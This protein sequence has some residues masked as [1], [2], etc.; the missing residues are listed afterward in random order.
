MCSPFVFLEW[1]REACG[2]QGARA[3]RGTRIRPWKRR[4]NW[5]SGRALGASA[6]HAQSL[7]SSCAHAGAETHATGRSRG[8][9]GGGGGAWRRPMTAPPS[10]STTVRPQMTSNRCDLKNSFEGPAHKGRGGNQGVRLARDDTQTRGAAPLVDGHRL[11]RMGAP[12]RRLSAAD[13]AAN[14]TAPGPAAARAVSLSAWLGPE[15]STS[16]LSRRSGSSGSSIPPV[17]WQAV[18]AQLASAR[19]SEQAPR[20]SAAAAGLG[21]RRSRLDPRASVGRRASK[22][23][24]TQP[25]RM[26]P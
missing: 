9:R 26:Y 7:E 12:A 18:E 3:S 1:G 2:C 6:A 5:H 19:T 15:R 21:A 14:V 13:S 17:G 22:V 11:D 10:T 25:G 23:S 4:S 20:P 8:S 16:H 24:R